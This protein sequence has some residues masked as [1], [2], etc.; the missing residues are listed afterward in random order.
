MDNYRLKIIEDMKKI[1][2]AAMALGMIL[3]AAAQDTYE[4]GRLL[5]QDLNGTARYV[6]M[7]G[8]MEA[9][10]A[11][12]STI[13]TNPAGLGLIRHSQVSASFGFVSQKDVQKFDNL[14]KTNMSFDQAGFVYN[15][16]FEDPYLNFAFNYH[17]SRNFDQILNVADHQLR[18]A[19]LNGLTY[20]KYMNGKYRLEHDKNGFWGSASD[21]YRAYTYN[22]FDD[23]NVNGL[24]MGGVDDQGTYMVYNDA[25]MY[26]FDRAHR[27]W[28]NNFDFSISGSQSDRLYWGV[29]VGL[30]DVNYKGY[31]EYAERLNRLDE[32]GSVVDAGVVVYGDDRHIKGTGFDVTAGIIVRPIENSPFRV[33]LSVATPT[34][35]DLTS[36]NYT[37]LC[38]RTVYADDPQNGDMFSVAEKYDF[39]YYTPWKFGVSLGHTIGQ[40]LALGLSYQ[41]TDYGATRNRV[42]DGYDA[43]GDEESY[44]DEPMKR[45]AEQVF[46]GVSTLKAGIEIKPVPVL[47]IRLGYNYV[48]AAYD[49]NGYRD[50]S[51]NSLGA[52]YASTADYVNWKD[53]NRFTCGLG[54][55]AGRMNIDLAYQYSVTNGVFHP[56]QA[57]DKSN[58]IS[59][60]DVSN[61][62]HQ[63]LMTLG[64]TF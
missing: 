44:T 26:N 6:G 39:K 57:Y 2:I 14:G 55:W 10:G 29:T 19:S 52:M 47:A 17:K 33:G 11:D 59:T 54:F 22:Q 25:D 41:Y 16:D 53:T 13:S 20:S 49:E 56:F 32:D 40:T 28:I 51:I 3:P 62:R 36:E 1:V 48:S 4:S 5:D 12:I 34:F 27:G 8:A 18:N 63:L 15:V 50:M 21:G 58:V 64:Y 35:Y 31:S 7:G 38:N 37:E 23:L 9:L 46:K 45:N 24:Y 30:K 60:A 42:K 61:K 43:Y